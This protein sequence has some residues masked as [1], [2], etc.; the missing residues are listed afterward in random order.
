MKRFTGP[1]ESIPAVC[2]V[3]KARTIPP[4]SEEPVIVQTDEAGK[5][6]VEA[7]SAATDE[8]RLSTA[9]GIVETLPNRPFC[10]MIA[11]TSKAPIDHP[12]NM[13]VAILGETPLKI[14][15][16]PERTPVE[17]VNAVPIYRVLLKK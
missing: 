17:S 12:K 3:A 13:K 11:N 10:T 1:I 4:N 6:I 15:P 8:N 2:R 14:V 7:L 5:F 16:V 9:K